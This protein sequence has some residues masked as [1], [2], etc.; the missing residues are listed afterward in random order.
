MGQGSSTAD[1]SAPRATFAPM[2]FSGG[3]DERKTSQEG[4]PS[5]VRVG[6]GFGAFH[7]ATLEVL[8]DGTWTSSERAGHHFEHERAQHSVTSS[9]TWTKSG[10][11]YR[12]EVRAFQELSFPRQRDARDATGSIIKRDA[13]RIDGGGDFK[14]FFFDIDV[15][16]EA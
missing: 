11:E 8:D 14:S 6:L 9:G 4:D 10:S 13:A 3:V 5:D 12:F 7:L 16:R 1:A 2:K 15:R